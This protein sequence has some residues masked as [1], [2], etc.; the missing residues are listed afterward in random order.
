MRSMRNEGGFTLLEL[1][2]TVS[3]IILLAGLLLPLI[4]DARRDAEVANIVSTVDALRKACIAHYADTG[5][6]ATE[7]SNVAAAASH[8]LSVSQSTTNW[9]GPYLDHPLTSGDNPFGGDVVVFEAMEAGGANA[10]GF[11]LAGTGSPASTGA[12]QALT[13]TNIPEM[14]AQA[15]DAAMDQ[16]V[17]GTWSETGRVEWSATNDTLIVYLISL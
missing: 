1:A 10:N 7:A 12:G 4:G 3:I 9:G 17:A 16:N 11:L 15:V 8:E 5:T 2:I 13:M 6:Y 14:V